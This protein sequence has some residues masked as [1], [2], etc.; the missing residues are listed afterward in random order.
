MEEKD[1]EEER[2][3]Q[4]YRKELEQIEKELI[5]LE[6]NPELYE[7]RIK[8]LKAKKDEIQNKRARY[9]MGLENN[10]EETTRGG[11]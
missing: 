5:L 9:L 8:E 7:E 10:E 2:R 4:L 6:K 1:L 11:R 3:K